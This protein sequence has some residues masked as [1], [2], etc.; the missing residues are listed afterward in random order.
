MQKFRLSVVTKP[1]IFFNFP[2]KTHKDSML[3]IAADILNILMKCH[4]RIW[5]PFFTNSNCKVGSIVTANLMPEFI[6]PLGR[7]IF[8]LL[9][10]LSVR[11]N[12][13]KSS[14]T[15]QRENNV[16]LWVWPGGSLMTLAFI[17]LESG[18]N[19]VMTS[20]ISWTTHHWLGGKMKLEILIPYI[21][22]GLMLIREPQR[23]ISAACYR[24]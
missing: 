15:K 4:I 19:F 16:R 14:K 22:E 11:H 6:D 9:V 21:P 7:I 20:A 8:A 1:K 5:S 3:G 13:S 12:F 23:R 24:G 17:T 10:R 2:I 18:S